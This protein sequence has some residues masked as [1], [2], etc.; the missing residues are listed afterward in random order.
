MENLTLNR[1]R[2]FFYLPVKSKYNNIAKF[3]DETLS[4]KSENKDK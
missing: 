1:S 4:I 2:E 3:I